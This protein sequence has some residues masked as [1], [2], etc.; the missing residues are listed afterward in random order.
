MGVS[1]SPLWVVKMKGP[2][3][4]A[5]PE[6]LVVAFGRGMILV[7]KPTTISAPIATKLHKKV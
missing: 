2:P 5:T 6:V 4:S 1:V 3:I 7:I